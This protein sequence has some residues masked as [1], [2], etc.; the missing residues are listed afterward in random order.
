MSLC[1][2]SSNGVHLT[3]NEA[4]T[5]KCLQDLESAQ[6][7]VAH[8]CNTSTLGDWGGWITWGQAF[9]TSLANTEKPIFTKN[10]K[11]REAEAGEL[12]EPRRWRS[13]WAEIVPLHSSLGDKARLCLKKVKIE[14]K[15]SKIKHVEYYK[16]LS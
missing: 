14:K 9:E 8:A 5:C 15:S 11:I 6:G 13:R 7:M 1:P 12:P 16:Y 3:Q 2:E 10:T 4:L